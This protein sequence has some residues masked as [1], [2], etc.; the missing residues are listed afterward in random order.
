MNITLH[1]ASTL[2]ATLLVSQPFAKPGHAQNRTMG[3]CCYGNGLLFKVSCPTCFT[4]I[5]ERINELTM[6]RTDVQF[7]TCS[8]KL[9]LRNGIIR[10]QEIFHQQKFLKLHQ[11]VPDLSLGSPTVRLKKEYKTAEWFHHKWVGP[12][13]LN[14]QYGETNKW[15]LV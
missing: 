1:A 7:S 11:A 13:N 8:S 14:V 10:N 15:N 12:I 2:R 9:W 5:N 3:Q 6:Q 4:A